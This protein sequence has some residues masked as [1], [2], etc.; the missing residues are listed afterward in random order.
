MAVESAADRAAFVNP[1]EFG[2]AATWTLAAGGQSSLNG[3]FSEG[4][5]PGVDRNAALAPRV[6]AFF[7]RT[8]D[9]PSGAAP[10]DKLTIGARAFRVLSILDPDATG[11]TAVDLD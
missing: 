9:L 1:D 11:M 10:G 6:P 3:V 7:C 4:A 2:S 5:A 8:A